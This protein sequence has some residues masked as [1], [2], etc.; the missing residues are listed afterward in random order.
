MSYIDTKN[1]PQTMDICAISENPINGRETVYTIKQHDTLFFLMK[2]PSESW[3]LDGREIET[4]EPGFDLEQIRLPF[5]ALPWLIDL[6]ENKFWKKTSEGG[7]ANN[8]LHINEMV[9]SEDLL[10]RFSPNCRAEGVQGFTLEN[11]SHLPDHHLLNHQSI[12]LPYSLLR[13]GG[14]LQSWKDIAS[15]N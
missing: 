11:Y 12:E 9:A 6:I 10:L 13:E 14:L 2:I 7:L 4:D 3:Y 1:L 8:V 15:K 5:R